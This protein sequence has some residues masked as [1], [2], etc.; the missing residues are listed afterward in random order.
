VPGTPAST[1]DL[2]GT[3]RF[4]RLWKTQE[5]KDW[6][7]AVGWAAKQAGVRV[8]ED[9]GVKLS[10]LYCHHGRKRCDIDNILKVTMDG[11][12]GV[13]WRDDR[14]VVE[15]FVQVQSVSL[16]SQAGLLLTLRVVHI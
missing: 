10:I 14:Q 7:A 3:N 15:L 5:A 9:R 8:S 1:N 4:G 11:L 16:Q 12:N 2:Y 6:A 13:A